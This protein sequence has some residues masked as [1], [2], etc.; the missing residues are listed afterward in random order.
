MFHQARLRGHGHQ[1][2][3]AKKSVMNII[4]VEINNYC[5]K[6]ESERGGKSLVYMTNKHKGG[7]GKNGGRFAKTALDYLKK[8]SVIETG[9]SGAAGMACSPRSATGTKGKQEGLI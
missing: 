7:K 5:R 1:K 6:G 2:D 3:R 4:R 9:L 8:S